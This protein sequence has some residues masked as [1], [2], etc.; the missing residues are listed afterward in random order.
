VWTERLIGKLRG[1]VDECIGC[2]R[3]VVDF[4]DGFAFVSDLADT[5]LGARQDM[6]I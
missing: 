6:Q 2:G 5:K 3:I 4:D 1:R